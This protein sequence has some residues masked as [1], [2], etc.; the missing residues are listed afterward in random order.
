M[1][2]S[3]CG[4]SILDSANFCDV[5]GTR[6]TARKAQTVANVDPV[7]KMSP[8][9]IKSLCAFVAILVLLSIMDAVIKKGENSVPPEIDVKTVA[10]ASRKKLESVYGTPQRYEVC[11]NDGEPNFN[12]AHYSWGEATFDY[13][14][15]VKDVYYHYRVHPHSIE[16]ALKRVGLEQT[17]NPTRILHFYRWC[18]DC[19][20]PSH[21]LINADLRLNVTIND[22]VGDDGFGT[23]S[24]GFLEW[25]GQDL[26]NK[27]LH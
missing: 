8:L 15:K 11:C 5:C 2:C 19:N 9:L 16:A 6:T 3:T 7:T 13:D 24:V 1:F 22:D 26:L 20:P 21:A 12:I 27:P 23:I 4:K 14:G 10:F 17:S 18:P 25:T